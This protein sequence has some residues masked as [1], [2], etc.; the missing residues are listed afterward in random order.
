MKTLI[1]V[2]PLVLCLFACV[3][4]PIDPGS[5]PSPSPS[6]SPVATATPSPSATPERHAGSSDGDVPTTCSAG[7]PSF[8]V[9]LR[10]AINY[11]IQN[12][13]MKFND[14]NC[15]VN[16][17]DW[18]DFYFSVVDNL[19]SFGGVESIVDDCGGQG[20]CG[21]LALKA[22]GVIKGTGTSEQYMVL[23]SSGCVAPEPSRYKATCKP[24][25]FDSW[26]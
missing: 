20:I 9:Q 23:Y 17:K 19:N 11:Y 3:T 13:A 22:S 26:K 24:A 12:H 10:N 6:A 7:K 8:T 21:E 18:D 25:W 4:T 16:P 2:L 15:M 1:L 5:S 14:R